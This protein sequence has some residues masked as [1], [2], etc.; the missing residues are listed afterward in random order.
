MIHE[1]T[2]NKSVC[3]GEKANVIKVKKMA[4]N[5]RKQ[6]QKNVNHS[7]YSWCAY[8]L[9]RNRLLIMKYKFQSSDDFTWDKRPTGMQKVAGRS[10][11]SPDC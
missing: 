9:S 10:N 3:S 8:L 5:F 7:N 1:N 6:P 11:P 4:H 2:N